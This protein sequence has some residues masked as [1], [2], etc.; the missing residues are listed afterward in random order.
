MVGTA[1]QR[2]RE[3]TTA[4]EEILQMIRGA[5]AGLNESRE[6]EYAAISRKYE[7]SGELDTDARLELFADRLRDYNTAVH[8]C[9]EH[10]I[11]QAVAESCQD[12][13]KMRLLISDGIPDT[14]RPN[15]MEFFRDECLP[16]EA[17]DRADGVLT[18]CAVAIARTGTIVL[19]HSREE[20]RR[21]L[22]LVPDFH[23]CVVFAEQVVETVP[24]AIQIMSGFGSTPLTTICGPS[25][26]SDIEMTRVKGVHGPRILKVVLVRA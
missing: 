4:R 24:E 17:L 23:I 11:A 8:V 13:G 25:A 12:F 21:A 1:R 3:M 2:K 19:R 26:T 18:G 7:R 22:S 9:A 16:Y 14:W 15:T 10:E 5:T 6:A 20:G